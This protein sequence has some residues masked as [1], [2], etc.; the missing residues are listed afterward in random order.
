LWFSLDAVY[1]SPVIVISLER[2]G[3]ADVRAPTEEQLS[4]LAIDLGGTRIK[5][6]L[7]VDNV[8]VR[9][10]IVPTGDEKGFAQ[11][12]QNMMTVG[13]EVV[14]G[15]DVSAIG[16][17]L[18]AIVDVD[19]GTV[20]D[21][22]KNLLGLIGFPLVDTL[23]NHFGLPVALE[24]DARLYGLGEL[25]AGAAQG[26]RNLVCLT[27]GTGVGCCVVRDGRILRGQQGTGGIL[28]GHITIEAAGPTCTCGNIGCVE[29]LCRAEGLVTAVTECLAEHPEHPL[30]AV[31]PLTPEG[32]MA[33][34]A[35][36]DPLARDG[37]AVYVR[38]LAAAVVSYIH[39]HDPDLVLLGGGLMNAAEH[40]LPPVQEYV[41]AHVWTV[42]AHRVPV[43]AAALGD[44]AAL[45]GAAALARGAAAFW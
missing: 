12:L 40:L 19:R 35:T 21:I 38:H 30:H 13:D 6:G 31:R 14:R 44:Y 3:L 15:E 28:G 16:L 42:P 45:I 18:P 8:V 32:I 23:S 34:V 37:V 20:V 4:T 22:R 2:R 5:A 39:A 26:V 36:G 17:S 41:H 7:V 43:R 10:L 11:V 27:L 25:V 33:A 9:H 29:A 1:E 24:N